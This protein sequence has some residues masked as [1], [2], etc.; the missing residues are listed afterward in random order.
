MLHHSLEHLVD[1]L[2]ALDACKGL[3]ADDGR[4]LVRIP[5]AGKYAWHKYGVNWVQLDA[6]R[7][8][9]LYSEPAF[10][11]TAERAG[12]AVEKILFDST[13]YQILGSEQVARKVPI[14]QG[15]IHPP[16]EYLRVQAFADELN[17][18]NDGDQACFILT[19]S[20]SAMRRKDAA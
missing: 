1:P 10:C 19:R 20:A 6:P 9:F 18:A 17:A 12:F 15:L 11:R 8:L 7:H 14:S 2:A 5:L 16:A 4:V 13:A 3:L